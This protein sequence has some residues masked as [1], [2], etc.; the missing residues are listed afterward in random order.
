M[1]DTTDSPAPQTHEYRVVPAPRRGERARGVRTGEGRFALALSRVVNHMAESGWEF[2]RTDTLPCEERVGL[3][4][5]TVRHH[6]MLVFR[7]PLPGAVAQAPQAVPAPPVEARAA[8]T[9]PPANAVAA[10]AAP[11]A[12]RRFWTGRGG[13]APRPA[14][15]AVSRPVAVPRPATPPA[16]R[17]DPAWA[18]FAD[19]EMH[20][21]DERVIDLLA[22]RSGRIAAE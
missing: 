7:R 21:D 15:E 14:A 12:A 4:Q 19:A 18:G 13:P 2:V 8:L 5:T 11:V 22:A 9:E 1:S 17:E 3:T 10:P 16:R 20:G 6:S